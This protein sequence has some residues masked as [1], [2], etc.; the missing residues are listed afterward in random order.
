MN[1]KKF[2]QIYSMVNLLDKDHEFGMVVGEGGA[3]CAKCM[4]VSK[5]NTK[6]GNPGF[7]KWNNGTK[8]PA[9]ADEYCC[10]NFKK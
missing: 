5:D 2:D 3:H 4:W 8:L 6:C 7:I 10:D 9:P 1:P